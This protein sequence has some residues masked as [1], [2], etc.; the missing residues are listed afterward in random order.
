M[1]HI[2]VFPVRSK[3]KYVRSEEKLLREENYMSI[4]GMKKKNLP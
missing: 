2:E 4:E 3:C 1:L